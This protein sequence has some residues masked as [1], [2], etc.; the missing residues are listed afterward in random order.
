VPGHVYNAYKVLACVQS[1]G[2]VL[3]CIQSA[4]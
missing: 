4:Q 2:N 3:A 1:A